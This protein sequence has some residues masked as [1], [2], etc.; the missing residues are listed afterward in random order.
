MR[1]SLLP[2][3]LCLVGSGGLF[4]S[5]LIVGAL[6]DSVQTKVPLLPSLAGPVKAI[7]PDRIQQRFHL[8]LDGFNPP[9]PDTVWWKSDYD[10]YYKKLLEKNP[11][12]PEMIKED[13]KMQDNIN[14]DAWFDVLAFQP[15]QAT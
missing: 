3:G 10:E 12:L 6:P 4:I 13:P 15:A 9:S 1:S 11:D 5:V 2:H 14:V 7:L 8:W